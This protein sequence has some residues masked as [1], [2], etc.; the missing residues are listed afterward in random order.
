[1]IDPE[2]AVFRSRIA[3][4]RLKASMLG[5]DVLL[6][7][8]MANVRY[9]VG[10][11]GSDGALI[12]GK[13]KAV[14][15]VDGRYTAQALREVQ[16][17]EVCEYKEKIGGIVEAVL[18]GNWKNVGLESTAIMLHDYLNLRDKLADLE[19]IP[20]SEEIG[21]IRAVKDRM[22]TDRIRKA[23]DISTNAL[24]STLTIVRPGVTEKEIA[25]ELEFQIR[26]GGAD[27]ISFEII[28][29][30][31]DNSAMPHAKPGARKFE[32]GDFIVFDYGAVYEGYRSDETC[33]IALGNISN[34]QREV[35]D[36]VKE[37]HDRAINSVRAG[38]PCREIDREARS[39]IEEKGL[40]K[41]FSHATGHGVGLCIH[42]E[43]RIS[44]FS[45][46][47]LEAGMVVT[48]EPGVYFP[49]LWGIRIEDTVLVK[50]DGCDI[51]TT[52]SKDLRIVG[53]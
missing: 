44:S 33:T 25:L 15:L 6:F 46:S 26:S 24:L 13:E 14:L 39:I 20:L 48:I 32:S 43:P 53:L 7:L 22:E 38:A 21:T 11:T 1:M 17:A 42:E 23:S 40:G 4:I 34:R 30:S 41:Y 49:G 5:L 37:A 3:R 51:L 29:A 36:I 50:E 35:Y 2:L 16:D 31:G 8:D 27:N 10:F 9:L 45:K 28:V 12:I 18:K 47:C 52:V 19:L